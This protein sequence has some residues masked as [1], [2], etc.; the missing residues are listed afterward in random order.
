MTNSIR[1]IA[2]ESQCIFIIGSNTT[3]QHPVIGTKIRRAKRHRGAKLIV[4]DPRRIDIADYADLFLQHKP[5]TDIALLNGLMHVILREGWQ[6][7]A[8]IAERSEGFEELKETVEKY[9]P[10]LVSEI[11]GVPAANIEKAARMMAENRPGSL[12]YAMGIT[13]HIV[14][15]ANVMSCANLQM[16]LGNMGVAGGGVNPLRGQN[17]V[18]GACDLGGLPN[19][20]PGYQSVTDPVI[21]EKFEKAWGVSLS[22][23]TGLTVTE[24]LHA[25]EAGRVRCIYVIG[26]N[27]MVS[28]P[29]LNHVRHALQQTEFLVVQDIF[30]TETGQ[31]ADVVLPAASFAEKSGTFTNTERRVQLVRKAIDPPG[32]AKPDTWIVAELAKRMIA[33]GAAQPDGAAPHAGWEYDTAADMMAEINALSPIYGGITYERLL[34]GARLR[35]PVPTG[36]HPGTP[37]LHVGRFSRGLGRFAAVDHVAPDEL[38]DED[39]PLM[40][41]TGR[42]IYHWHGGEM[43]RRARNLEAMYPEALIEINPK[44]AQR[45]D[46]QDGA[47][48][49]VASRRGEIIAKAEVTERVGPG[50]IFSTFHFPE[51]AANFLTNPALDPQAKIPEYKVCAVK[52]QPV[53]DGAK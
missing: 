1:D 7:D 9:T 8:F 22:G 35:W 41:T 21:Q 34:K 43:T 28:D 40:L 27:P 44:D 6:D 45:A 15:V 10:E 36:E 14:G 12:L 30:F 46:I 24:M 26:E 19:V 32:E 29:D 11:T 38:P 3:E 23:R 31:Y 50:L 2:D 42:V 18:Q 33:L 17:N 39:Y 49:K 20:Y 48:M 51:S 4:A 16:L 13:Q 47:M 52:I 5:G 25:A 53:P 37:I